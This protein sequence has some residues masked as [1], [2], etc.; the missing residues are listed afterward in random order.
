MLAG[1]LRDVIAR[2]IRRLRA[3]GGFPLAQAGVLGRLDR[4]GRL[5]IGELAAAERVRPQSMSQT[6]GELEA[7]GLVRRAPDPRDARRILIELTA[8]GSDALRRE[9]ERRTGF[10]TQAIAEFSAEERRALAAAIELLRRL[11]ERA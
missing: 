5:A 4:E 10:L 3:E 7:E 2:M 9:R 1:E 8:A 11:S 6:V